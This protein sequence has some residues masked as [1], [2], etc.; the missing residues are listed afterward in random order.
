MQNI[1]S[2]LILHRFLSAPPVPAKSLKQTGCGG[3]TRTSD[4]RINKLLDKSAMYRYGETPWTVQVRRL[5]GPVALEHHGWAWREGIFL[6]NSCTQKKR[7]LR[8]SR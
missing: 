6:Y 1:D 3:R 5:N 7:L 2:P 4:H 8:G